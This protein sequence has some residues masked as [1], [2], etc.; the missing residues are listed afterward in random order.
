MEN[1]LII[2]KKDIIKEVLIDPDNYSYNTGDERNTTNS[3]EIGTNK[4]TD[5]LSTL[6]DEP[7]NKYYPQ[8]YISNYFFEEKVKE[9][10][11][12]TKNQLIDELLSDNDTPDE[13]VDSVVALLNNVDINKIGEPKI[14]KIT[15]KIF[16]KFNLK[17]LDAE[18]KTK[19]IDYLRKDDKVI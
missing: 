3:N 17:G 15:K 4:T 14:F 16:D 6:V 1:K 11:I 2:K 19:L 8:G 10:K 5:Q 18:Y 9:E 12:F 13:N 7:E